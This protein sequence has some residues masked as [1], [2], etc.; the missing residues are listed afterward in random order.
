M[1]VLRGHVGGTSW[2]GGAVWGVW[3]YDGVFYVVADSAVAMGEENAHCDSEVG[4]IEVM[5]LVVV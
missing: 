5:Q 3:G 1:D 4:S 2:A